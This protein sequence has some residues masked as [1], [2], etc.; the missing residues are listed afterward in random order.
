MYMLKEP[1]NFHEPNISGPTVTYIANFQYLHYMNCV[2]H[3]G[4]NDTHK[5]LQ[6]FCWQWLRKGL[7]NC[8]LGQLQTDRQHGPHSSS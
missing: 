7:S 4:T 1:Y 6:S 2:E 8:S 5:C 3:F